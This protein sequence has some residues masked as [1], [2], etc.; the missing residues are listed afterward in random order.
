MTYDGIVT[1]DHKVLVCPSHD[2]SALVSSIH[3]QLEK[4]YRVH[5]LPLVNLGKGT[6]VFSESSRIP[7]VT[8]QDHQFI[9]V[10]NIDQL[11]EYDNHRGEGYIHVN[12]YSH[13]I[14]MAIYVSFWDENRHLWDMYI[15]QL[16]AH[17]TIGKMFSY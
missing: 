6:I 5:G 11:Y 16:E 3:E 12:D 9:L 8:V 14:G 7:F 4:H 1:I 13:D 2:N 15:G 10:H 17:K